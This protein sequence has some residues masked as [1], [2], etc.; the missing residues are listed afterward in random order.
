MRAPAHF[1][2]RR[3]RGRRHRRGD[4][5]DADEDGEGEGDL[6][7]A[8]GSLGGAWGALGGSLGLFVKN[9]FFEN[10]RFSNCV[11][12]LRFGILIPEGREPWDVTKP[13]PLDA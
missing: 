5:P 9:W 4:E 10:N 2:R 11:F 12:A 3:G 8:G 1:A 7:W 13:T 6:V